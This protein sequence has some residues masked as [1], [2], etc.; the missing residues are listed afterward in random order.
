MTIQFDRRKFLLTLA[1]APVVLSSEQTASVASGWPTSAIWRLPANSGSLALTIDDG[2]SYDTVAKYVDF[3]EQYDR[4]ITFFV[5]TKYKSWLK[6]QPRLQPLVDSGQIQLGNHTV[7]HPNLNTLST[8]KVHQELSGCHKFLQEHF[9]VDSRP[10]FRPPYG[11]INENVVNSAK[12]VGYSKPILWLGSLGDS[13]PISSTAEMK[14]ADT[15]LTADRIVIGHANE[16]T[17][18]H[19]FPQIDAI[20]RERHLKTVTLRDVF[21]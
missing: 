18:T 14:L 5:T 4:R 13:T 19:L 21:G 20:L 6:V 15:W 1:A 3:V 11:D 10:Y 2:V 9:G 7:T 17:V 8:A 16:P 12:D